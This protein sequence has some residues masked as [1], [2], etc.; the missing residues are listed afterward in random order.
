MKM[1]SLESSTVK[2]KRLRW[3]LCRTC[4]DVVFLT[5]LGVRGME[6]GFT[7]H[8]AR[9]NEN[10]GQR[11][12]DCVHQQQLGRPVM[13]DAPARLISS[14]WWGPQG[15]IRILYALNSRVRVGSARVVREPGDGEGVGSWRGGTAWEYVLLLLCLADAAGTGERPGGG[16]GGANSAVLISGWWGIMR[17]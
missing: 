4:K 3:W 5:R 12:V 7:R 10:N 1:W 2:S 14:V 13:T 16:G 8:L 15:N 6:R 17:Y 11:P 9:S